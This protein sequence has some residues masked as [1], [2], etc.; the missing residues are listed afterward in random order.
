MRVSAKCVKIAHDHEYSLEVWL[1]GNRHPLND[2]P[3]ALTNEVTTLLTYYCTGG[4]ADADT[5]V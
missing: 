5:V 4:S 2:T 3:L 1:K